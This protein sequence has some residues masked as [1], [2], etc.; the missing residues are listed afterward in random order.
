MRTASKRH[1]QPSATDPRRPNAPA[2]GETPATA[3]ATPPPR[4]AMRRI[5]RGVVHAF[6]MPGQ[7]TAGAASLITRNHA[8]VGV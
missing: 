5:R 4:S 1:A 3:N 2:V 7:R 8:Y 6:A